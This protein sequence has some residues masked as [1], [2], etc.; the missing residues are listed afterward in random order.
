MSRSSSYRKKI[1]AGKNTAPF[2]EHVKEDILN[3]PNLFCDEMHWPMGEESNGMVINVQGDK[4][5][6]SYVV[7]SAT[8]KIGPKD[9]ARL[10]RNR[11]AGLQD[12]MAPRGRVDR[13]MCMSHQIRIPKK[14]PKHS[15]SKNDA[16][17]FLDS[18]KRISQ[19]HCAYDK[20]KDIR[21]GRVA[22]MRA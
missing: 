7:D 10:C 5:C 11:G 15:A 4:I 8:I 19:R 1:R 16:K 22:A 9:A 13:Q 3:E 21:T 2:H 17:E 18:A 12:R 6:L 14:D 20:I